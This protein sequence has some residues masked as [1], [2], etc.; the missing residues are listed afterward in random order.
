MYRI[1]Q[2]KFEKS[3]RRFNAWH[4]KRFKEIERAATLKTK[5]KHSKVP[6]LQIP[7]NGGGAMNNRNRNG[8]TNHSAP[9]HTNMSHGN[10][11]NK[12]RSNS[13]GLRNGG[14]HN[15]S[16]LSNVTTNGMNS[17]ATAE[18]NLLNVINGSSGH[19]QAAASSANNVGNTSN[20]SHLPQFMSTAL[21]GNSSSAMSNI[22]ASTASSNALIQ[23]QQQ[24]RSASNVSNPQQQ[25][26]QYA[27]STQQQ[28]ATN[29]STAGGATPNSA[30]IYAVTTPTASGQTIQ[31]IVG[32]NQ[33]QT[34]QHS[35]TP[36]AQQPTYYAYRPATG[37]GNAQFAIATNPAQQGQPTQYMTNYPQPTY[38]AQYY[39]VQNANGSYVIQQAQPTGNQAGH[40]YVMDNRT[41]SIYAAFPAANQYSGNHQQL[42][43]Q[44]LQTQYV[45][46][47]PQQLVQAANG[48]M[49]VAH[50][51]QSATSPQ[52]QGNMSTPPNVN[53]TEKGSTGGD[54]NVNSGSMPLPALTAATPRNG[55]GK[56]SNGQV[57]GK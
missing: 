10:I 1:P 20:G 14:S 57:D 9:H 35:Q 45:T 53:V 27:Q 26:L 54:G 44:Q 31:P 13:I 28:F 17:Q 42:Y 38:G 25:Q 43:T 3:K 39:A 12:T 21:N 55:A 11:Q 29:A 2:S 48:P 34:T 32:V 36:S 33:Q 18:Q 7:N 41:G 40:S 15:N 4:E 47:V 8:N 52:A 46:A 24:Q 6:A 23:Q 56:A 30:T 37:A 5:N 22:F 51:Q 16:P 50:P 49:I 19:L